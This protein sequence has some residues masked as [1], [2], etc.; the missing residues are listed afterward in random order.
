MGAFDPMLAS[1]D[2]QMVRELAMRGRVRTFPKNSLIIN[3][4]DRGDAMYVVLAG[5]VQ[6][7]VSDARGR[8]MIL[9]DRGP[10]ELFGEMALDGSPRSASVRALEAVTCA[11]VDAETL[12]ESLRDPDLA[13]QLIFVLIERARAATE[14]VM[15]LALSDVYGRVRALLM[16]MAETGGDGVRTIPQRMTQQYIASR[17][18]AQRDMVSRV[19]SQLVRGGYIAVTDRQYAILRPLPE[20]F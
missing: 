14:S 16:A 6:V 19:C 11:V 15:S 20:R 5:Q 13:L 7:Y 12:R 10:G 4:G 3:Q 1:I 8:E 2:D 18:G 17:V 9:D